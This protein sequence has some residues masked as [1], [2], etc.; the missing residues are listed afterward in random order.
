MD[1]WKSLEKFRSEVIDSSSD[2]ESKQMTHNMSFATASML[3][4]HNFSQTLVHRG[5]VKGH[6][7][8]L[9]RHLRLYKDYFDRTDPVYLAKLFRR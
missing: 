1:M 3:H 9:Q 2:D 6:S 8:N 4:E 5:S 7:K